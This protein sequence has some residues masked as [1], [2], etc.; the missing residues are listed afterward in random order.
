MDCIVHGVSK[1]W[2]QLS[3]FHFHFSL[4]SLSWGLGL[5]QEYG[6]GGSPPECT[7]MLCDL[8]AQKYFEQ[9]DGKQHRVSL[10]AG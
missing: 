3:N 6:Q 4:I 5:A 10:E 7:I 9:V 8:W 1:S 2:R